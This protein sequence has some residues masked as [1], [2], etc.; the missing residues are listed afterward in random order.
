VWRSSARDCLSSVCPVYVTSAPPAA[1]PTCLSLAHMDTQQGTECR[2]THTQVIAERNTL[3]SSAYVLSCW[4][5]EFQLARNDRCDHVIFDVMDCGDDD[6]HRVFVKEIVSSQVR[7]TAAL[8]RDKVV[9]CHVTGCV[10]H[11]SPV[12]STSRTSLAVADHTRS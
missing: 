5:R 11:C 8:Y 2:P 12:H 3:V 7:Q 6:E 4:R 10:R 1:G 9:F